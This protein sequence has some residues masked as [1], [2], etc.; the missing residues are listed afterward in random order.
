M[1]D[2]WTEREL[3]VLT[4]L[5]EHFD[6]PDAAQWHRSDGVGAT[7]LDADSVTRAL[8]ALHG[9]QPPYVVGVSVEEASY[10]VV[11]TGV[12]ERARRAVGA[13]P[14]PEALVDRLVA[15]L[16]G[17]GGR[18]GRSRAEVEVATGGGLARRVPPGRGHSGRHRGRAP[19]DGM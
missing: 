15:A 8:A 7:G 5:V 1:D 19:P 11:L 9:A 3:P 18:R 17:G 10:P 2:T 6:D 12:T 13:W 4:A 14:T 16:F